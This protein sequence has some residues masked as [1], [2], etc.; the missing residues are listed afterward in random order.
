[1]TRI[2]QSASLSGEDPELPRA[3]AAS[4]A[5]FLVIRKKDLQRIARAT[6]GEYELTDVQ[7]EAWLLAQDLEQSK[8]WQVDLARPDEQEKFLSYLYQHLVRYV[9]LVVRNA[10]RLDHSTGGDASD[11]PHPLLGMLVADDG[12]DPLVTLLMEEAARLQPQEPDAHH[13]LASA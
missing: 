6:R 10:V 5:S 2:I 9:E 13:S 11:E 1:V 7:S 12:H 8:K 4:F 3:D